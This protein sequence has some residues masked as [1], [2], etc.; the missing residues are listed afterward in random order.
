MM[1]KW[2]MFLLSLLLFFDLLVT[3]TSMNNAVRHL[4]SVPRILLLLFFVVPLV[5]LTSIL[6]TVVVF[7]SVVLP[8]PLSVPRP[9]FIQA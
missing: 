2:Q 3:L 6:T 7:V 8:M 1:M 4:L 9:Y 5:T